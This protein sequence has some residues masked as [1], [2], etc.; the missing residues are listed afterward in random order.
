M[1]NWVKS[2][3]F[4]RLESQLKKM[5]ELYNRDYLKDLGKQ[6]SKFQTGIVSNSLQ[7]LGRQLSEIE[8]SKP[9]LSNLAKQI[10]DSLAPAIDKSVSN[11]INQTAKFQQT[12]A[13]KEIDRIT[14]QLNKLSE[15]NN[16]TLKS[17][18][19]NSFD[20]QRELLDS[21]IYDQLNSFSKDMFN[22]ESQ[23]SQIGEVLSKSIQF[24]ELNI[25]GLD[26]LIDNLNEFQYNIDSRGNVVIENDEEHITIEDVKNI[27]NEAIDE[28]GLN[29][30]INKIEEGINYLILLVKK[31]D[32]PVISVILL[33]IIINI[34]SVFIVPHVEDFRYQLINS[35]KRQVVK[36]IKKSISNSKLD[37]STI[38]HFRVVNT[39]CLNV[40]KKD[41]KKSSVVGKLYLGQVVKIVH[42]K[43]NWTL[44]KWVSKDGEIIIKG[45]VFTRY[46]SQLK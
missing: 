30:Q 32:S 14:N 8:S 28:S 2:D 43:R 31:L 21:N 17:F 37:Y 5:H 11:L 41:T 25:S 3:E 33:G 19:K 13:L 4:A 16:F 1:I 46:I 38:N 7:Q 6:L 10:S 36:K 24:N 22:F 42:K 44:I 40:R 34:M 18:V 29:K 15:M 39:K 45:W 27:V 9:Q 26:S 23:L 20:F 35:N 12:Y